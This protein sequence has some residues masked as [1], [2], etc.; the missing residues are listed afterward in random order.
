[1][2]RALILRHVAFEDLGS[3]EP[4]LLGRRF[5]VTYAEAP[6]ADFAALDTVDADLLVVLGGPIGVY[7]TADYPFLEPEIQLIA[8]RLAAGRPTLGIC[9]GCQLMARALGA[10]VFPSGLKEIGWA[11]VRLTGAGRQ[12]CLAPLAE[13]EAK[14]LHWH[15]DTFDL[16]AGAVHLA[17]TDAC[18]NQAFSLGAHAL[19]L[20]FHVE[21]TAAGLESWYVGHTAEIAATPGVSVGALRTD[22]Q[23]FA[24]GLATRAGAIFGRWLND[25][26]L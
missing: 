4:V 13:A 21:A 22:S 24:A 12:S 7:D 5:G 11:P 8:R 16:P 23:R 19:A 14:V 20:Q 9:L 10:R 3:L 1:M 25:A 17:E 6:T 26:G 2:K 18:R 15:G